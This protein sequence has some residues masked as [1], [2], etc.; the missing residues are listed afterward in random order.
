MIPRLGQTENAGRHLGLNG[1]PPEATE[2]QKLHSIEKHL[3][4]CTDARKISDWKTVLR[5]CDAALV[6]GATSSPQVLIFF[7]GIITVIF[8]SSDGGK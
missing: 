4:I 7:K 8:S 5:E 1:Q 3:N 6:A 2:L